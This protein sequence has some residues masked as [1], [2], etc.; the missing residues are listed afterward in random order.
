MALTAQQK[1]EAA[2]ELSPLT[3]LVLGVLYWIF[4]AGVL[5]TLY[6]HHA[7]G[8]WE[9]KLTVAAITWLLLDV[10]TGVRRSVHAAYQADVRSKARTI[11]ASY[12][13][14]YQK[15]GRLA[16]D[17]GTAVVRAS[18]Q[19]CVLLLAA[20][21]TTVPELFGWEGYRVR[22]IDGTDLDGTEHRLG[23]LRDKRSAGLPGRF[24]VCYDPATGLVVDAVASE[25]A[26]T[27]ERTPWCWT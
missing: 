21:L 25:D 20:A 16:P 15:Y 19:R 27:S 23:V 14:L 12:Q 5:K 22:V 17:Y 4:P 7:P 6:Q 2:T 24:V 1:V 13:A 10:V 3:T 8:Q 26:Y 11:E 18:A 9:R